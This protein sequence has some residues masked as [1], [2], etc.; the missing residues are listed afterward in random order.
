MILLMKPDVSNIGKRV[1]FVLLLIAV[2]LSKF[3]SGQLNGHLKM[4]LSFCQ[5]LSKQ[6]NPT[7]LILI[8]RHLASIIGLKSTVYLLSFFKVFQGL[9]FF[10]LK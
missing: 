7:N 6:M 8:Q 5:V 3:T 9:V 2:Y 10:I 4:V 1:S